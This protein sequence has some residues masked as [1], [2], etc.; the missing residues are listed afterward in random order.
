[1]KCDFFFV[2]FNT[3]NEK[4]QVAT[5][6]TVIRELRDFIVVEDAHGNRMKYRPIPPKVAKPVTKR[7]AIK[8]PVSKKKQAKKNLTKCEKMAATLPKCRV[9]VGNMSTEEIIEKMVKVERDAKESRIKRCIKKMP[10]KN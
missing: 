3:A 4:K 7:R 9:L 2:L 5:D 1:M 6:K 10:G 8:P